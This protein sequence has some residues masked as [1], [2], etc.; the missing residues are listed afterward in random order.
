MKN[1]CLLLNTHDDHYR[2]DALK[3]IEKFLHK[4]EINDYVKL[5][6]DLETHKTVMEGLC[7]STNGHVIAVTYAVMGVLAQKNSKGIVEVSL[8]ENS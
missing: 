8:L 2:L 7:T 1:S 6:F 4:D 5:Y 3:I